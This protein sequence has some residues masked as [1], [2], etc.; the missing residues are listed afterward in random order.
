MYVLYLSFSSS[1]SVSYRKLI[2][3]S[4]VLQLQISFISLEYDA[5]KVAK[6]VFRKLSEVCRRWTD[7]LPKLYKN[8]INYS[9]SYDAIK[10][11]RRKMEDRHVILPDFNALHG[12]PRVS[13]NHYHDYIR[14]S[15]IVIRLNVL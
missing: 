2:G 6:G 14:V 4:I 12:V 11:T 8:R 10:N 13:D 9:I 7:E 3:M 1:T 5:M 15:N